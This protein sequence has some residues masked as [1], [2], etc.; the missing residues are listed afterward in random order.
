MLYTSDGP[1]TSGQSL[2]TNKDLCIVETVEMLKCP[3]SSA[4]GAEGTGY[5]SLAEN[6]EAFDRI[7][8]SAR[9]TVE[10]G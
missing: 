6:L 3:A 2:T 10:T 1:P 7:G 4:H 9:K 5:K 8:L